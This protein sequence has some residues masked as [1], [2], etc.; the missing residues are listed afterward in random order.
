MSAER[1][2]LCPSKGHSICS[3]N[4]FGIDVVKST[5]GGWLYNKNGYWEFDDGNKKWTEQCVAHFLP[6][7]MEATVFV[8][9]RVGTENFFLRDIITDAFTNSL[10]N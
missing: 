9:S 7:E 10:S 3:E 1:I 6:D 8:N 2:L 4:S 5:P